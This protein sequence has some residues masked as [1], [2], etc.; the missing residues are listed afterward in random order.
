LS[1]QVIYIDVEGYESEVLAGAVKTVKH[2]LDF[3]IEVHAGCGLETFGGTVDKLLTLLP[4]ER[5]E[6]S[7][8]RPSSSLGAADYIT[9][10]EPSLPWTS[11]CF[12]PVALRNVA[13]QV[14]AESDFSNRMY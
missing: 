7:A 11:D 6:L 14:L 8:I 13:P 4:A 2:S 3:Y 5:Y 9:K 10:F 1:P 12:C